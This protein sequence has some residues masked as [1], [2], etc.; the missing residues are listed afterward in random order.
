MDGKMIIDFHTHI[1]PDRIAEGTIKQLS[2]FGGIKPYADGRKDGLIEAMIRGGIDCSVIL[3]VVTK[4]KQ[5]ESITRF[6]EEINCA[7]YSLNQIRLISFGGIHPDTQDYKGELN[8]LHEKGFKG[9]KLHP[10]Y[11]QTFIDDI[12]YLR[13]IEYASS[14]GMVII[15]HAGYDVGYPRLTH[16][17]PDRIKHMLDEVKPEKM[18]LAHMG[19]VFMGEWVEQLLIG[20]HVYLDTS[21]VADIMNQEQFVRMVRN[22]GAD[23]ILFASDS[24]WKDPGSLKATIYGMDFTEEEREMIFSGNA[25]KLLE[26]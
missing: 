24:P 23:K 9:I 1:F 16:C 5:F 6:A 22:H 26:I 21:F 20:K 4:P 25:K 7:D 13:I 15:T 14:L 11:Q 18:V 19:G 3:P 17:T 12:K 8:T 10:D 2:E